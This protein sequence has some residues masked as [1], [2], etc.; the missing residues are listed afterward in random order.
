MW[1]G[2]YI[3]LVDKLVH[4]SS[5]NCRSKGRNFS[6]VHTLYLLFLALLPIITILC[7]RNP[8]YRKIQPQLS[9]N[10]FPSPFPFPFISR[11]SLSSKRMNVHIIGL[12]L[13]LY[14]IPCFLKKKK[15]WKLT[16]FNKLMKNEVFTSSYTVDI[17]FKNIRNC[18]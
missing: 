1:H 11:M 10:I 3:L 12:G 5:V 7:E 4:L 13:T 16:M 9:G 2:I 8:G 18:K 17:V 15:N 14:I 6:P